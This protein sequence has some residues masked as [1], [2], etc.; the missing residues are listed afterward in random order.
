MSARPT[1]SWLEN[2]K[3]ALISAR[4]WLHLSLLKAPRGASPKGRDHVDIGTNFRDP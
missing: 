1:G 3:R 2:N 4:A